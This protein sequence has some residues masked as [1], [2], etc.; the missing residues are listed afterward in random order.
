MEFR[1]LW[2][3]RCKSEEYDDLPT[4]EVP[5]ESG[6]AVG[7]ELLGTAETRGAKDGGVEV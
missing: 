4:T 3:L 7:L 6:R 1:G 5:F 2:Q